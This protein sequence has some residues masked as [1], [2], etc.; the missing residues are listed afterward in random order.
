MFP[1]GII[2]YSKKH[3]TQLFFFSLVYQLLL[4]KYVRVRPH[5]QLF[6]KKNL[7]FKFKFYK[8]K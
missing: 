8:V 7:Y 4:P 5:A 6:F 1:T 2:I 3:E